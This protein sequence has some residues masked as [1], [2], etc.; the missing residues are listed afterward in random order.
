MLAMKPLLDPSLY[1]QNS[2]FKSLGWADLLPA[3]FVV[4]ALS[5]VE[6]DFLEAAVNF[7]LLQIQFHL[8]M[9]YLLFFSN[10]YCSRSWWLLPRKSDKVSPE[11]FPSGGS[12]LSPAWR[13][14]LPRKVAASHGHLEQACDSHMIWSDLF[15]IT[16]NS[17]WWGK[18]SSAR[19]SV[20]C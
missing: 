10:S 17:L 5:L 6:I 9:S 13:W 7:H 16:V 20:R 8:V 3:C 12:F 1:I 4:A 18:H 19:L 14:L 11:G 2:V 15:L